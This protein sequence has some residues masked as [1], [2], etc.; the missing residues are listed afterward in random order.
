MPFIADT[1]TE[2]QGLL[3]G[4]LD[5]TASIAEDPENA[6]A[7]DSDHSSNTPWLILADWLDDHNDPRA[8]L[9]RI[10]PNN[11]DAKQCWLTKNAKDWFGDISSR[12]TLIAQKGFPGIALTL[13]PKSKVLPNLADALNAGWLTLERC[14]PALHLPQ[15]PNVRRLLLNQDLGDADLPAITKTN[16]EMLGLSQ[17]SNI[18]AKGYKRLAQCAKLTH[19]SLGQATRFTDLCLQA[20]LK[21]CPLRRLTLFNATRFHGE[22]LAH[23]QEMQA[24]R[25]VRCALRFS[26]EMADKTLPGL[27]RLCIQG[28]TNVRGLAARLPDMPNLVALEL[29]HLPGL[30]DAELTCL[31]RLSKLEELRL[32]S[33]LLGGESLAQLPAPENLRTVELRGSLSRECL[34]PLA[35]CVNLQLLHL[36]GSLPGTLPLDLADLRD[37]EQLRSLFL[38]PA[39]EISS[40]GLKV[41]SNMKNLRRL[42]LLSSKNRYLP[43]EQLPQLRELNL[44]AC[45]NL[46]DWRFLNHLPHLERLEITNAPHFTSAELLQVTTIGTL[47]KLNLSD[48][49]SLAT[50]AIRGVA[51]LQNLRWLNVAGISSVSEEL[52]RELIREMPQ[53]RALRIGYV[54]PWETIGRL[55]YDYPHI[56]WF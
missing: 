11:T 43:L 49:N 25:A 35:R 9:L 38:V 18:S 51:K 24:I 23:C 54:L 56:Q 45:T 8:E 34:K 19:L 37:L 27:R 44:S 4:A 16:V 47:Q 17:M 39:H 5:E 22:S 2:M 33:P 42:E 52:I 30:C 31:A 46:A 20:I 53:L 40:E 6:D 7:S 48:C 50:N 29:A 26:P 28:H 10:D 3:D 12:V 21:G 36:Q 14:N 1:N 13:T 55:R 15:F 41:L 32:S